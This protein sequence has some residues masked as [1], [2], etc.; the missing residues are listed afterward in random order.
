MDLIK[1]IFRS[2]SLHHLPNPVR[3]W[4]LFL[5]WN[6]WMLFLPGCLIKL[7]QRSTIEWDLPNKLTKLYFKNALFELSFILRVQTKIELAENCSVNHSIIQKSCL[8]LKSN[9]KIESVHKLETNSKLS[10]TYICEYP[11]HT[12]STIGT[13]FFLEKVFQSPD[14]TAFA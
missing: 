14:D 1:T 4:L 6:A 2:G 11:V 3:F 9:F 13:I 10:I 5:V 12:A 8:E 7:N